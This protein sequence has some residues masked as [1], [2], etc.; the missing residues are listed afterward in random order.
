M[1]VSKVNIIICITWVQTEIQ[2]ENTLA[3]F[4]SFLRIFLKRVRVFYTKS[5]SNI[6]LHIVHTKEKHTPIIKHT[7]FNKQ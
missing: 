1:Q 4:K 5:T 7:P 2:R 6:D 3:L